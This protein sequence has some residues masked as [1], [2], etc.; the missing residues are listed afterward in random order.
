MT[1][2]TSSEET[3][4]DET[5]T[6]TTDL[7]ALAAG[8]CRE[9]VDASAAL[10]EAF[11]AP[12]PGSDLSQSEAFEELADRVPDEIRDDYEVLA[13]AFSQYTDALKDVDVTAGE[14]PSAETLQAIQQAIASIDPQEVTEASNNI[15]A[16]VRANCSIG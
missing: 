7:G 3:S 16:W 15:S 13:D 1:E 9:L 10:G 6:G 14:T 8:D 5:T 11:A 2:T 4:T 12:A